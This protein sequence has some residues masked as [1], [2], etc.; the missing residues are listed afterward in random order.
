[1]ETS[2]VFLAGLIA[3]DPGR[4]HDI[5]EV[6]LTL[7]RT[8]HTDDQDG[9]GVQLRDKLMGQNCCGN[10]AA[11]TDDD[12]NPPTYAFNSAALHEGSVEPYRLH[13]T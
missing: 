8:S 3:V 2:I 12:H 10:V 6:D 4:D 9:D 11:I 1:V 5:A 13:V 7:D